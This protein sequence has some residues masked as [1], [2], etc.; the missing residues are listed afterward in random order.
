MS[1]GCSVLELGIETCPPP[2][3]TCACALIASIATAGAQKHIAKI[4]HLV[5]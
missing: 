2:G 5:K 3:A 1:P 4:H